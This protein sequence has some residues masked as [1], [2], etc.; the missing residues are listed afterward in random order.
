VPG[1]YPFHIYIYIYIYT[2]TCTFAGGDLIVPGGYPFERWCKRIMNTTAGQYDGKYPLDANGNY[3]TC[4]LDEFLRYYVCMYVCMCM[5]D[6]KYPLD[7]GCYVCI[8]VCV[9]FE[10]KCCV[11][12]HMCVYVDGAITYIARVCVY[13]YIYIYTHTHILN[14]RGKFMHACMHV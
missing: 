7:A 12:A 6:G 13:I 5:C 14:G 10:R 4:G 8:C 1:G 3:H 11:Y 2:H 9:S